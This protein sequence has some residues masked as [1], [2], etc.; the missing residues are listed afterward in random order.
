[1]DHGYYVSY[2][3]VFVE[4][5]SWKTNDRV[6]RDMKKVIKHEQVQMLTSVSKD[7]GKF[8]FSNIGACSTIE[9]EKLS[10]ACIDTKSG[11]RVPI[12]VQV[13]STSIPKTRC[14]VPR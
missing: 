6:E 4:Q 2:I 14:Y 3:V 9:R 8:D 11:C 7:I 10:W 1:M 13:I 5:Q 12:Q